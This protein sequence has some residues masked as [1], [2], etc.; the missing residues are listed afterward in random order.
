MESESLD[1]LEW[2]QNVSER[3]GVKI[4]SFQDQRHGVN[5]LP[6]VDIDM[7]AQGNYEQICLF[8]HNLERSTTPASS[9]AL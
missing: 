2:L 6:A 1:P 4:L 7:K 5:S 9:V 3:S 8:L